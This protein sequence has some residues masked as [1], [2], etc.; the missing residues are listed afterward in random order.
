MRTFRKIKTF[1]INTVAGATGGKSNEATLFICGSIAGNVTIQS[2]AP[3]GSL[4]YVG[5]IAL[6]AN[7]SMIY[8]AY[9]YGWTAG[10][11]M[12]AYELF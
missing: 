4:V 11:T 7:Q 9:T 2:L 6:S 3:D 12:S 8:P 10:V 5:P 1:G